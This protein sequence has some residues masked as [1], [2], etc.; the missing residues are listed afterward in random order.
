MAG[1]YYW[2]HSNSTHHN[3]VRNIFCLFLPWQSLGI[4][5]F[6]KMGVELS[7]E[8]SCLIL[9]ILLFQGRYVKSRCSY[10]ISYPRLDWV[11][12]NYPNEI[13]NNNSYSVPRSYSYSHDDFLTRIGWLTIT[14]LCTIIPC[15]FIQANLVSTPQTLI[16]FLQ[17]AIRV[18]QRHRNVSSKHAALALQ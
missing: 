13:T 17:V 4:N 1:K 16:Y 12:W 10:I 9:N 2:G 8:G 14:C 15:T 7:Q 5:R 3:V 11:G 18:I 6:Q